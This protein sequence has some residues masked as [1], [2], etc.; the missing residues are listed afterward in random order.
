MATFSTENFSGPFTMWLSAEVALARGDVASAAQRL[1][2]LWDRAKLVDSEGAL[3]RPL[4]VTARME[5]DRTGRRPHRSTRVVE[6]AQ[7]RLQAIRD[8]GEAIR[9]LGPGGAAWKAHLTAELS[10]AEGHLDLDLWQAAVDGWSVT[11]QVHDRAWATVHL[12]ECQIARGDRQAAAE[13]LSCARRIGSELRAPALLQAVADVSHRARL[14]LDAEAERPPAS[15]HAETH[16]LTDREVEVLRL[17]GSGRTNEQIARDL[18]ISPKTASAHVSHILS[19]LDVGS[20]SQATTA[21]H[22]LGLLS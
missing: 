2:P 20:R 21:G 19:K 10:R 7:Q 3:W 4:L 12:A 6:D 1:A 16:G 18:F 8:L 15:A 14:E 11:G 9:P 5:A 22:R 17:V 13:S